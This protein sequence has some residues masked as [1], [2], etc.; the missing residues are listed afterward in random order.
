[1]LVREFWKLMVSKHLYVR[2]KGIHCSDIAF[3]GSRLEFRS[4]HSHEIAAE[5]SPW[6]KAWAETYSGKGHGWPT[7]AGH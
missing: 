3:V 4:G 7:F 6:T 1:M 5:Y 2:L